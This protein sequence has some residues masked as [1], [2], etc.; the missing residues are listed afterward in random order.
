MT[1]FLELVRRMAEGAGGTAPAW[2]ILLRATVLLL[3][4]T[5]VALI[6]RRSSAALRHLVWTLALTGTL[7]IPLCYCALPAW[8]WAILPRRQPELSAATLAPV[9]SD[10]TSTASSNVP[11]GNGDRVEVRP[12]LGHPPHSFTPPADQSFKV[13]TATSPMPVVSDHTVTA[14]VPPSRRSWP[15]LFAQLWGLGIVL[16]LVWIGTGVV[17]AWYVARRAKSAAESRWTSLLTELLDQCG[18]RRSIEIRECSQVSVPMTWGLFRPVILVPAGSAAWSDEI[19]RS[20]LLHE[21]GHIR[22]GDC[23]MLLLGRLACAAYWFHPLAWLA[24]RQ[25]RRSSEQAADDLVLASN[26]A[27][28]DYAE[29]LVGIAA[30]MRGLNL[31]GHV[32]LPMAGPSDLEGRVLAILDPRRNRRSLK[33]KTCCALMLLALLLAIPC[34]IL[35]LGYAADKK[36]DPIAAEKD[37]P[38][39]PKSPQKKTLPQVTDRKGQG[40]LD[41]AEAKYNAAKAKAEDDIDVRYAEAARDVVKAEYDITTKAADMNPGSVSPEVLSEKML[42]C[43]EFDLAVEQAHLRLRIAGE[44]AKI[45]KAEWEG[46]KHPN[47]RK[48]QREMEVAKAEATYNVARI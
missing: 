36:S 10:R 25:L 3:V 29:H 11:F 7:L 38:E 43:K 41:V 44:E 19:K 39:D 2:G 32:A 23:P 37:V 13:P 46:A 17:A 40:E 15:V 16:G 33:R 48:L 21:L 9:T 18:I 5:L 24:V 30:R 31:F 4:A 22:R 14:P 34:A 12:D 6:L 20:V 8:H 1:S 26:I 47:D 35:R 27:P 45:A 28:P 42:K